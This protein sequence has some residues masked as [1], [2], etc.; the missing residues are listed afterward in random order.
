VNP[1]TFVFKPDLQV[2]TPGTLDA[3]AAT[4]TAMAA[5][6]H[7]TPN[8]IIYDTDAGIPVTETSSTTTMAIEAD[9]AV[10]L[11]SVADATQ[12]PDEAGYL[13][14]GLGY[15]YEAA[16]VPYLGRAGTLQLVLDPTFKFPAAVPVGSRVNLL[17]GPSPQAPAHPETNGAFYLT[18][19]PVG[20]V[21][22]AQNVR[23][24]AAAGVD[25]RVTVEYPGDH[26]LAGEGLPTHGAAALGDVVSVFAGDDVDS[27]VAAARES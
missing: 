25:V 3:S 7:A 8:A 19:S 4:I 22:A 9:H 14:V 10:N 11:L 1:T 27:E 18:G 2:V 23:K 17:T 6:A 24:L 21:A 13:V 15:D 20:R 12:F 16:P 26:G 5:P